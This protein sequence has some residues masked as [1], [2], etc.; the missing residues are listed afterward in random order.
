MIPAR[1]LP[2]L[3]ADDPRLTFTGVLDVTGEFSEKAVQASIYNHFATTFSNTTNIEYDEEPFDP[4]GK[5]EWVQLDVLAFNSDPRRKTGKEIQRIELTAECWAT[6][7]TNLYRGRELADAVLAA[8]S[9]Q[10]LDVQDFDASGDPVVGG[11]N[12]F[13]GNVADLT[14]EENRT[15]WQHLRVTFEGIAQE[16]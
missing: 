7:T 13:E 2:L 1:L 8:F 11:C 15:S 4:V 14:R 9:Q 12:I 5:T 3:K 6:V 16:V 10:F